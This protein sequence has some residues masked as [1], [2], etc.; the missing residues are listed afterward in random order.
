MGL[1]VLFKKREENDN[2]AVDTD[3]FEREKQKHPLLLP[4]R[5]ITDNF[6]TDLDVMSVSK[7]CCLFYN[8]LVS[9][10]SVQIAYSGNHAH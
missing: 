7:R 4:S 8:L 5:S 6:L 10:F 2:S 3:L 9:V 1:H